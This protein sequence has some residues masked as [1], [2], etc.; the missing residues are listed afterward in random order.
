MTE[1][2]ALDVKIV[3]AATQADTGDSG[4]TKKSV[5]FLSPAPLISSSIFCHSKQNKSFFL[6][7]V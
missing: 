4:L 1:F 6:K 7:L 5:L 2:V 3:D